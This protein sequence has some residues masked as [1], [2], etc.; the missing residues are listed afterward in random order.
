MQTQQN[1]ANRAPNSTSNVDTAYDTNRD[2]HTHKTSSAAAA[3]ARAEAEAAQQRTT[4]YRA[5]QTH[6]TQQ[7]NTPEKKCSDEVT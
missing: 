6:S 1:T 5:V 3:A 4:E 2:E 7:S